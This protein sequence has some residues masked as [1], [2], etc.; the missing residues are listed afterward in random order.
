MRKRGRAAWKGTWRRG[1]KVFG[2]DEVA[3][4]SKV[5]GGMRKCGIE[6]LGR[7]EKTWER[8]GWGWSQ[9]TWQRKERQGMR[10]GGKGKGIMG[11]EGVGRMRKHGRGEV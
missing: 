5:L 1:R 11:E 4:E 9:E 7:D 6:G 2:M 10:K 8:K 3:W